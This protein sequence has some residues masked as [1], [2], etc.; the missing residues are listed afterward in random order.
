MSETPL[1]RATRVGH[2]DVHWHWHNKFDGGFRTTSGTCRCD[3]EEETL[4]KTAQRTDDHVYIVFSGTPAIYTMDGYAE[5]EEEAARRTEERQEPHTV[6]M[7]PQSSVDVAVVAT[8]EGVVI[9]S[10]P[11][12]ASE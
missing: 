9:K 3:C 12:V 6:M 11:E 10:L 5:A 4:P 2:C 8:Y 7:V 1:E